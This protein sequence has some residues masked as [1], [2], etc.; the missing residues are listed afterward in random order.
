MDIVEPSTAWRFDPVEL[1]RRNSHGVPQ[2][3]IEK[4]LERYEH[5]VTVG[6][7]LAAHVPTRDRYIL[8]YLQ[9]AWLT[10][11]CSW[12]STTTS[13]IRVCVSGCNGERVVFA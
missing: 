10:L 9:H 7:I 4:M 5:S 1:A 11:Y 6:S 3:K 12:V 13:D 8:A 2:E